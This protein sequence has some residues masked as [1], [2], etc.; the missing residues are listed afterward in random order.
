MVPANT[1]PQD[2]AAEQM[3]LGELLVTTEHDDLLDGIEPDF[4]YFS[5]HRYI[6]TT[7][8]YLH[9]NSSPIDTLTVADYLEQRGLLDKAGNTDYLLQLARNRINDSQA[10]LAKT[11]IKTLTTQRQVILASNKIKDACYDN[12]GATAASILERA[13]TALF[14]LR[15]AQH[16]ATKMQSIGQ[17]TLSIADKLQAIAEGRGPAKGLTTGF[18][19]LD[20][21]IYELAPGDLVLVAARPSQGKTTF[22]MNLVENAMMQ[23]KAPVLVYS[24]EMPSEQI[25]MRLWASLARV[26]LTKIRNGKMDDEEWSRVFSVISTLKE[27]GNLFIDDAAALTPSDIRTRTRNL[28]RKHGKPSM[29]MVDYVQLMR[30]SETRK[31]RADEIAEI[32]NSLKE[33][34]KDFGIPVVALSQLNRS[35]ENR[36]DK[37]PINSDLRES[38]SL[39]Q[40]ADV[41]LFIYRDEVYNPETEHPGEAEIIIGKQRNGPTGTAHLLFQ[42]EY[43]KFTNR[44]GA[45]Q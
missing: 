9:Q 27:R 17:M 6:F 19:E 42:G 22:A 4:F 34:A 5:A 40:D 10:M 35:L 3:L 12:Q 44:T 14:N 39:E 33:M 20:E 13:E 26:N 29:L 15:H 23:S 31:N 7:I 28:I 30:V 37:R 21:L 38:G 41:I 11:R 8:R 25:M 36:Q 18:N 43:S 16:E 1:L 2:M 32:S 45:N 24:L